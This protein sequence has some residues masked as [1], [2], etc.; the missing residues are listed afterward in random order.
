MQI[1]EFYRQGYLK[2]VYQVSFCYEFIPGFDLYLT[3]LT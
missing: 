2:N 1:F 3:L